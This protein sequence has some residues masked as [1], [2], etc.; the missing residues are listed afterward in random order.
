MTVPASITPS[1]DERA[2]EERV[3]TPA[4]VAS[5][6][7]I[8]ALVLAGGAWWEVRDLA[9]R[10][11]TPRVLLYDDASI[12]MQVGPYAR[13]G[14]DIDALLQE[15]FDKA[16]AKGHVI[17]RSSEEIRGGSLSL[18][19]IAE[20]VGAPPPETTLVETDIPEELQLW[21]DRLSLGSRPI[22]AGIGQ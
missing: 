12:P 7:A 1:A 8:F 20:F 14:Y 10:G 13:A 21:L 5:C 9:A 16:V 4:T 19:N 17:I 6:I 3:F 22:P 15:A 18:F 2:P 11:N